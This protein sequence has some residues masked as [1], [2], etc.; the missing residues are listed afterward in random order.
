MLDKQTFINKAI[1]Y[2]VLNNSTDVWVTVDG[3]QYTVKHCIT[4]TTVFGISCMLEDNPEHELWESLY[5]K[6]KLCDLCSKTIF[7]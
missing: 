4:E 3:K 1:R 2:G 5:N 7:V 6:Y